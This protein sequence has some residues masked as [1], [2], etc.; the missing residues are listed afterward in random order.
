MGSQPKPR[1][2]CAR[3][4]LTS[5]DTRVARPAPKAVD[6]WYETPEHKAWAKA[7]IASDGGK[8]RVCGSTDRPL[9]ADHI[10]EIKDGGAKLDPSN[11]QCLCAKHH[12]IKTAAERV[13]RLRPTL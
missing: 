5:I 8:C 12:G 11:G 13:K 6:A 3:P 7:V 1:L 9:Y 2:T 4:R 10:I